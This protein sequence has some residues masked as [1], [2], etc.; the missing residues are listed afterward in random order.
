MKWP[1]EVNLPVRGHGAWT[2]HRDMNQQD[3][4]TVSLGASQLAGSFELSL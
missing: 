1:T 3:T 2:L 4:G